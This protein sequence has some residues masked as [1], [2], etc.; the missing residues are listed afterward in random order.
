[1]RA[2]N[3][4]SRIGIRVLDLTLAGALA[5]G[6]ES[7]TAPASGIDARSAS[8]PNIHRIE[9]GTLGGLTSSASAIN[10]DGVVVGQ[11]QIAS[12]ELH[13]FRWTQ[14]G[15]MQDLGPGGG[16]RAINT[17]GYMVGSGTAGMV[18]WNPDGSV[19]ASI[20]RPGFFLT[21]VGISDAGVVAGNASPVSGG[22]PSLF[23]WT[24]AGG[25]VPLDLGA[26]VF[27]LEAMNHNGD[28][29]G[30]RF[31]GADDIP[32]WF[33][34][35]STTPSQLLPPRGIPLAVND[36]RQAVGLDQDQ[37]AAASTP[38]GTPALGPLVGQPNGINNSGV[39]VGLYTASKGHG[40]G[41]P[42]LLDFHAYMSSARTGFIDL[43]SGIASAV[44]ANGTIAG[45]AFTINKHTDQH[46]VI[47]T[48]G[49]SA[50]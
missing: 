14:A 49:H 11:S 37:N 34:S 45:E 32:T 46:A 8:H 10:D 4:I 7:P 24:A 38:A 18:V 41:N 3:A 30:G 31:V 19:L 5:C 12:G 2:R 21:P 13:G 23:T 20:S 28:L 17:A 29:V 35:T 42:R 15:G 39:V 43:G 40:T 1:M 50:R 33:L 44:N 26:G 16:P 9:L 27:A 22:E 47:W 25:M 36:L 48:T 6:G